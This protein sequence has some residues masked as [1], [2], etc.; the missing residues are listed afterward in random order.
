MTTSERSPQQN[1]L[2]MELPE[3]MSSP[4]VFRA[5]TSALQGSSAAWAKEPEAACGP[6]SSDLLANY[7]RDTS[8]W[9]T[10]QTCLVALAKNEADG[11]AEFSET[12]PSA[13]MMRNGATYRLAWSVPR[14]GGSGFGLWPTPRKCTAMAATITHASAWDAGRFPNLETMVGRSL[15][16]TPTK[17]DWKGGRKPE[18]I[19]ASGRGA[20]N[21][22]NDALTVA[23]EHGHL[24]PTWVEWL[25]GFPIGWTDLDRLE[26][27]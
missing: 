17:R 22:L 5:K 2:P 8:S 3:L 25:M 24:N 6:K 7:S 27:P 16:P 1:F 19:A 20:T 10:S 26:T 4:E 18:T 15:W 14:T 12:W 13:G 11:L 9:R 23:G 21:S